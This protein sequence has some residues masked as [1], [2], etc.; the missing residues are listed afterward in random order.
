VELSQALLKPTA[1]LHSVTALALIETHISW[2]FLTG[3]LAYKIKKS[4]Q[5]DFLDFSTLEKRHLYCQ[6]E[7]RLNRR[8][9][10]DLYLQVVPIT[11]ASE[12][13]QMGGSGEVIEYAVQMRQFSTEQLLSEMAD[14]GEL[15][16][17]L[18]EQLAD[19]VA[20]FHA[21]A[22]TDTTDSCYGTAAEMAHWF[23]GNFAAM[24]PVLKQAKFLQQLT[25]LERWGEQE[26]VNNTDLIRQRKQHGFIRECHGDLHLGNIALINKQITPFDGIEFN[27]ALRWIDVTSEVAFVVMDL[28]QRG[29]RD[30]AQCF[31]NR[32]LSR[33]GDYQGLHLLRYYLVY[34]ALV[35]AKVAL[36]RWLQ[37]KNPQAFQEME[38]YLNLAEHFSVS[39]QS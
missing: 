37:H 15:N 17:T 35:R 22:K 23:L 18:V 39:Q 27:P 36:L 10:P 9:A 6:E 7:L 33:N 31:L 8:F 32:Y 19:C 1:Y 2:V 28:E 25:R 13:V 12:Q 26:L 5:F 20:D 11:Q 3:Q 29:M 24:R 14:K 38:S 16:L 34:R 21:Q 4:V 30:F